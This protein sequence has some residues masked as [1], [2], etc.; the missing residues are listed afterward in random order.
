[1]F[2]LEQLKYKWEEVPEHLTI[3]LCI[4]ENYLTDS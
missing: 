3:V 2:D 4:Y 1:M